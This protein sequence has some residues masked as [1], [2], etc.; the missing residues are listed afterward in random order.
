ML[1]SPYNMSLRPLIFI[2]HLKHFTSIII[3]F[4]QHKLFFMVKISGCV[5]LD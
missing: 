4:F 2:I 1:M 5:F 3:H